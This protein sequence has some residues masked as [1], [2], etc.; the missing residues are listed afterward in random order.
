MMKTAIKLSWSLFFYQ[1][2]DG[3]TF[4][5]NVLLRLWSCCFDVLYSFFFFSLAIGS[6]V[7]TYL[8]LKS[9]QMIM[10]QNQRYY[11]FLKLNPC[12]LFSL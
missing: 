2:N 7:L 3:S 5:A 8:N 11:L 6:W 12:L 9:L 10:G 4:I 1:K